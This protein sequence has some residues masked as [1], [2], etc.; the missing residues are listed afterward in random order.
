MTELS[1]CTLHEQ[2]LYL[3]MAETYLMG[4]L[5]TT[6]TISVTETVSIPDHSRL[7]EEVIE[8]VQQTLSL[9]EMI[10]PQVVEIPLWIC[11]LPVCDLM[12]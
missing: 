6:E 3:V 7:V 11:T 2:R 1:L 4:L 10:T 9:E 8:T 12:I 5:A